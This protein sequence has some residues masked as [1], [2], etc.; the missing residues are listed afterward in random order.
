MNKTTT[1]PKTLAANEAILAALRKAH[2]IASPASTDPEDLKR[3][4]LGQEALGRLLTPPSGSA[5]SP[6]RS[7][8]SPQ[9]GSGRKAATTAARSFCTAMAAATPAVPWGTR[10]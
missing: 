3:Q 8:A 2:S 5:G 1:N 7:T 6:L 10:G 4:R 9:P